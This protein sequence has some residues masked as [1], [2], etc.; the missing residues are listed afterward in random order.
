MQELGWKVQIVPK[1]SVEEG[2]R[3]AR[4][5][6]GQVYFDKAKTARLVECLKR[7]RRGIP[8]TTGEP[9]APVHDEFS[10]G[11]DA[12]RYLHVIAPKMSNDRPSVPKQP[13]LRI[14]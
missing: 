12:Y 6:F 11:A 14:A 7:Y 9:G 2:I 5:Q 13:N 8:A 1:L 3:L 10:H 4:R